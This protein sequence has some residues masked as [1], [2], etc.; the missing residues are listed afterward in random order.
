MR[1][2]RHLAKSNK[3][4]GKVSHGLTKRRK[5]EADS[6]LAAARAELSRLEKEAVPL[7]LSPLSKRSKVDGS[8][9]TNEKALVV[10][11]SADG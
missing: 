10:S 6:F 7:R 8:A 4:G 3:S 11:I 2:N 5:A 9:T 1:L